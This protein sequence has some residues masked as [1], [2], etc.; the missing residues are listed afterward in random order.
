LHSEDHVTG[1][2]DN[3][4]KLNPG[5]RFA[6][7][8]F[9]LDV[10]PRREFGAHK[11]SV[12]GLIIVAGGP[13]YIGAAALSAMAA[14]RT[15]AGIVHVAIPR[16]AMGAVASLVPEAAFI[17]LT[18]GDLDSSARRA[19]EAISEKLERSAAIVVGPGMG[20]DDYV[21]AL[22]GAIFGKYAARKISDLGFRKRSEATQE[23]TEVDAPALLG[24]D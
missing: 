19:R 6:D 24:G 11:W 2:P 9:A 17:P 13:G 20:D 7:E 1:T 16:G 5:D 12:G 15:G 10:L 18:E 3:K 23:S 4:P 14:G 21:D 22:L 8:E